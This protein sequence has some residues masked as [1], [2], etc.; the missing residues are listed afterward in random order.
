[1]NKSN[2]SKEWSF[3]FLASK[4]YSKLDLWR[5]IRTSCLFFANGSIP[6][7]LQRVADGAS[8]VSIRKD[9]T[10]LKVLLSPR[11]LEI[12]LRW[13]V[14][15]LLSIPLRKIPWNCHLIQFWNVSF[16]PPKT[17]IA[18]E[19]GWLEKVVSFWDGLFSGAMF[20]PVR[21][22]ILLFPIIFS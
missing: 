7:T 14:C 2:Q 15:C 8:R 17:N 18:P 9:L 19:N 6:G 10:Y 16:T 22:Y 1:M 4:T 13:F 3:T 12:C 21:V 20:V 5:T 11:C